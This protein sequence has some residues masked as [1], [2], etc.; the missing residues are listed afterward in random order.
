MPKEA[1]DPCGKVNGAATP[2]ATKY[3]LSYARHLESLGEPHDLLD[4]DAMY[5]LTGSRFYHSGLYTPGTAMLQPAMYIRG[6]ADGL[7]N[8]VSVFEQSPVTSLQRQNHG[9]VAQTPAG[10]VHAPQVLIAANGHAESFGF[11]KRRLMHVILFASM[12]RALTAEEEKRIGGKPRWGITPSNSRA[13]SMR[14]ISGTGGTRILTRNRMVYRP[15]MSVSDS[16]VEGM[17]ADHDRAF[18]VRYPELAGMEQEYRW[19][20]RLCLSYN[21]ASAFGELE[22]GLFSACCQNG[23]GTARGTLMGMAAAELM[24]DCRTDIAEHFLAEEPPTKLPPFPLAEIGAKVALRW[25]E[26]RARREL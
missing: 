2:Q 18:A 26:F 4:A 3:N 20:G 11:F 25:G 14:K 12:T 1:F 24:C 7:G 8:R 22:S 19:A 13:T 5:R 15:A 9:W 10:S 6:L 21:G 23:L 17:G 16:L